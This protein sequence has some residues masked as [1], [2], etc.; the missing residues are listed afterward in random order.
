[1]AIL[2][3]PGGHFAAGQSATGFLGPE[4]FIVILLSAM[5]SPFSSAISFF[6][7]S[8]TFGLLGFFATAC[9]DTIEIYET[10]ATERSENLHFDREPQP[11]SSPSA[12]H[13]W[14]WTVPVGWRSEPA[15]GMRRASFSVG[16]AEAAADLSVI[17]LRGTAGGLRA[18]VDRW[19]QQIG[20]GPLPADQEPAVP[21]PNASVPVQWIDLHRES[22]PESI[23]GGV[24]SV[25]G[26]T[27]FFKLMGPSE[28][29]AAVRGEFE[30][31]LLSLQKTS[32]EEGSRSLPPPQ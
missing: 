17:A 1:M 29:I 24:V 6:S 12:S 20:L 10:P 4:R 25:R 8:I 30:D 21:L 31:F 2:G 32:P 5:T 19:R 3:R 15:S 11:L 14:Q 7:K 13:P 9:A 26:E 27:W 28:T 18:N 23:L 16:P 22:L